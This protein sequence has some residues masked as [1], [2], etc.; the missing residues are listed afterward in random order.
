[1]KLKNKIRDGVSYPNKSGFLTAN[2]MGGRNSQTEYKYQNMK[3]YQ[4][5]DE[6]FHSPSGNSQTVNL[7]GPTFSKKTTQEFVDARAMKGGT[8]MNQYRYSNNSNNQKVSDADLR[9]STSASYF[10][11]DEQPNQ[12][13][14]RG[15]KAGH[16]NTDLY[17]V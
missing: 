12:K 13:F 10:S 4:R 8:K 9:S 2:D 3:G 17:D 5:T 6:V 1:M 14:P 7:G 16:E 11:K 15:S